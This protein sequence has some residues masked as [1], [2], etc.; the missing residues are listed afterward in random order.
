[1]E[2]GR[3]DF[4]RAKRTIW[5][6]ASR[7]STLCQDYSEQETQAKRNKALAI[8]WAGR[9]VA[10]SSHEE[11]VS[12][13]WAGSGQSKRVT[14]SKKAGGEKGHTGEKDRNLSEA[15]GVHRMKKRAQVTA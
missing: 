9:D 13:Q 14:M 4:G 6:Q 7:G 5:E 8:R 15:A 1:M 11:K 12:G 2:M 10:S 3:P